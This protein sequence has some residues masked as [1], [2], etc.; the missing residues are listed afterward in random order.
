MAESTGKAAPYVVV[1]AGG[2][3]T[4]FWPRSRQGKPKQLLAIW[5]DK[6]LLTHTLERFDGWPEAHRIVVTTKALVDA[7]KEVLAEVARAQEI[8]YLGEPLAKN[9]APCIYW[10]LKEIHAKD[11]KA[12]VCIVPAD[13]YVGDVHAFVSSIQRAYGFAQNFNGIVTLGVK[14][15][16]PETGYGYIHT[17]QKIS[18]EMYA[19]EQFV[20][21]P[22]LRTAISYLTSGKYLWNAGIFICRAEVGIDAFK[23]CMPSLA[24]TFEKQD[25]DDVYAS[26]DSSSA[27][28]I[29]FGVME[30]AHK[31]NIPVAVLAVDYVWSDLGSYTALE[32]IDKTVVGTVV[33]HN[34]ASNIVQCDEGIVALLGV[35][36]LVVVKDGDA[37]LVAS[38]GSC[39]DI[40]KLVDRIKKD[41]PSFA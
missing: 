23:K 25:I 37:I 29:D 6:C 9:T 38:K 41:H 28:S 21:K 33:S 3:G 30:L 15:D 36:D 7:S 22:D 1:I 16:R 19:V 35:N 31:K 20:E 5:D 14:P 2:S 17:A 32:E 24:Q 11:P 10:A 34:A 40:R 18:G 27:T 39:Q 8:T 12:T 13:H 4:R 26:L